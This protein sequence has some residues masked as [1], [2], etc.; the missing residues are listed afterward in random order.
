MVI[1]SYVLVPFNDIAYTC[2]EYGVHKQMAFNP[3]FDNIRQN[4][5]LG[6][7]RGSGEGIPLRLPR[8]VRRRVGDLPFEWLREIGRKSG[9]MDDASEE[10]DSEELDEKEKEIKMSLVTESEADVD[11]EAEELRKVVSGGLERRQSTGKT[12]KQQSRLRRRDREKARKMAANSGRTSS[13]SPPPHSTTISQSHSP[14]ASKS[15]SASPPPDSSSVSGNGSA[16]SHQS[17]SLSPE[18][19]VPLMSTLQS[20]PSSDS[21]T[22]GEDLARALA[23]QFYKIELGEQRRLMGV[24][25]H[26]SKESIP[27][28]V[29]TS[30]SVPGVSRGMSSYVGFPVDVLGSVSGKAQTEGQK[31]KECVFPFSITAGV[32]KGEKNR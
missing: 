27:V 20:S 22:S 3:F 14:R 24:M 21:D 25:E 15:G 6:G 19:P 7:G 17:H 26:H 9:Q 31:A 10:S 29:Q 23:M 30:A 12:K 16:H 4:L 5:E 2:V 32:E 28:P 18:P 13:D 8:R 11:V 1:H